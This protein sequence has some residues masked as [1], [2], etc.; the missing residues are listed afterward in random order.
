M[1]YLIVGN[2]V[3][4]MEAALGLRRRDG[5]ARITIVADEHD[6]FYSRPALMYV[7]AGQTSLR[8]TEPYDRALYE[9]LRFERVRGRVAALD[10]AGK[11]VRMDEGRTIGYDRLL[12]AVGSTGRPAPWPG[13]AGP[14][15]HYFVTLRD[16]EGLDRDARP[17]RHAVVVGGGLIG[18]EVA[19]IL[20]HRGLKVT[21][22]IRE[23]WY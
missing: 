10:A 11:S 18:V 6:H 21:F 3:G 8:D 20:R 22:V 7:F 5:G 14:G 15:L 12:L 2:G 4:G 17:G 13:A 9:R 19:E 16:L 1:H 23:N